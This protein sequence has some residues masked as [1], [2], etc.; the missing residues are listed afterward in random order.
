MQ[1]TSNRRVPKRPFWGDRKSP[2]ER[3]S[4]V[5]PMLE[6]W[7][8]QSHGR[9]AGSWV[10]APVPSHFSPWQRWKGSGRGSLGIPAPGSAPG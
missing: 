8:S 1:P 3:T 7:L 10:P 2:V 4:G 6:H 9:G 5:L